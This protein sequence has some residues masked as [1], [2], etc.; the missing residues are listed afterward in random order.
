MLHQMGVKAV[1]RPCHKVK[2]RALT[3]LVL[4]ELPKPN[5]MI[6]EPPRIGKTDLGVKAF[7]PWGM[8]WFPDSEFILSSYAS[9]LATDNS[10]YIRNTLAS[11]WYRSMIDEEW[12]AKVRIMGDKAAG[13]SDHFFTEQGGSVK[14]VGRG[15]GITGF[16]AGKLRKEFGGAIMM[17]DMMKAQEAKSPA[18]RAETVNY[19]KSTLKSRRNRLKTPKT[20]L[21]LIMQRLHNQDL[22]GHLLK[23]ER[24]QWNVVQI[25][26]LDENDISIWEDRCSQEEML[27]MREYDPETFYAQYM[28]NPQASSSIILKPDWWKYWRNKAALENRITLK[29][30]TADTAFK[31]ADD[32]DWSVFQCWGCEGTRGLHLIDQIRGRWEFPELVPV[33]KEFWL[34]H[35]TYIRGITPASEF[36]I[37]DKASGISLIQTMRKEPYSIPVNAWTPD[38]M[39]TSPD[40]VGRAKQAAQPLCA[41][42]ISVPDPEMGKEFKFSRDLVNE[43]EAFTNDDSHLYDD[44]VDTFTQAVSIWMERGGGT[45]PMPLMD[46]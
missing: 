42:R 44:Q 20:P 16:G 28:Q 4:G 10:V 30:I 17:D 19:Y 32:N 25:P 24:E 36:W 3:R 41:G 45:G 39:Q 12:G 13:R 9:S 46:S 40:K 7:V 14:A 15:G 43:A 23:E 21:V 37:E 33:A 11:D 22:A 5:L 26:A 34:K 31:A 38:E 6:L 27:E 35:S 8:S 18:I 1:I 2:A 29:F